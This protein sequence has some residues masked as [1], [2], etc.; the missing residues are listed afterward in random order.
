MHPK[1]KPGQ[2]LQATTLVAPRGDILGADGAKIVTPRD[3]VRYGI[4]KVHV[5]HGDAVASARALATLVGV[6]PAGFAKRVR[7]AGE[8][9][10]VEAITLR[11]GSPDAP[12][13]RRGPGHRR[14]GHA[15][16]AA[17]AGTDAH[18]RRADPRHGRDTDRRD[19]EEEQGQA[20]RG[21][22]GRAQRPPGAVRRRAGRH[23][24]RPGRPGREG[25]RRPSRR[26]CS[27]PTPRPARRSPPPST[28]AR[29]T[30]PNGRSPAPRHRVRWSRSGPRPATSSPPRAGRRR[31]A[32]TPPPTRA[33]HP[34]R[35]SRSSAALPCCDP[36]SRRPRWWTAHPP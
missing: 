28:Y 5:P 2:T 1:L 8:K 33:T 16:G 36:G 13:G 29:R 10:F 15:E 34:A 20:L 22:P 18:V 31:R 30:S 6:D 9:A 27:G 17:P 21:R 7:K 4:D 12:H 14:G 11:S 23:P 26:S 24:R 32:T 19:G 25:R 35:P 3:V